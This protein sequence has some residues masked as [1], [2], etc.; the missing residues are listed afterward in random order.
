MAL[1]PLIVA[2]VVLVGVLVHL[3][4]TRRRLAVQSR[5][6]KKRVG[7]L[8]RLVAFSQSLARSLDLASIKAAALEHLPLLVPGR[9]VWVASELLDLGEPED[10]DLAALRFPMTVAG[11]GVGVIGVPPGRPLTEEQRG[12]LVAAAALLAVSVKNAELFRA[13]HEN[14]VRDA[15]TGCFRRRHALEVMDVELKRARRSQLP[16]SLIMFDLDHF[17]EINDRYGHLCGDAVLAAVGQR[18]NAVLRVSDV[19]CR[20]GGEEFL[21]LLPDTPLPGA[22]KVADTLRRE[23]AEHPI[24]WQGQSIPVSASFGVTA[25]QPGEDNATTI[26]SRADAALYRA[27]QDGRNCVRVDQDVFVASHSAT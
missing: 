27:K 21:A 17:K 22:R 11:T 9:A 7:D 4:R 13:V 23:L 24:D 19:K 12:M 8:E 5:E 14:S 1:T 26:I 3:V 2:L 18:M 20:F 25:I 10:G 16:L 6:A 15:L